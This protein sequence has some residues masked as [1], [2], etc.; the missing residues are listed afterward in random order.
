LKQQEATPV[1]KIIIDTARQGDV[2]SLA[3]FQAEAKAELVMF[4]QGLVD[5]G[6]MPPVDADHEKAEL[7]AA[8][9]AAIEVVDEARARL[10]QIRARYARVC[11]RSLPAQGGDAGRRQGGGPRGR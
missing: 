8:M 2:P 7:R 3:E 5:A 9:A 11:T 1:A 10:A 4:R 6:L